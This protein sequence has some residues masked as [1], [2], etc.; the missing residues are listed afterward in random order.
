MILKIYN[1]LVAETESIQPK[2]K[3]RVLLKRRKVPT[4]NLSDEY[5]LLNLKSKDRSQ[6]SDSDNFTI[7]KRNSSPIPAPNEA[8]L[9][10]DSLFENE[11][12]SPKNVRFNS[13]TE[14]K[15]FAI[16]PEK[17]LK[18]IPVKKK[19]Q[20]PIQDEPL[21]SLGALAALNERLRN[22]RKFNI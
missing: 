8:R 19:V 18:P 17:V 21:D 5:S 9:R 15:H 16:E 4:D 10:V 1:F 11:R 7:T 13:D 14:T 3:K 6:E 20:K 22:R 2:R 12:L